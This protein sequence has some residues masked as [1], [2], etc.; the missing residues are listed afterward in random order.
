M[1]AFDTNVVVRLLLGDDPQQTA[2][3]IEHWQ[4]ALQTS[5]VFLPQVVILETIWVLSRAAKL[6]KSRI[7]SDL[8]QLVAI[9]GVSL[10]NEAVVK[11]AIERFAHSSA[12]FGDCVVLESARQ[13][14]ALPVITFD[15][16]FSRDGDVLLIP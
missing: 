1:Q 7:L 16:R 11:Q 6:D 10:E 15:Q 8:R 14:N 9:E 3:A 4:K 2:I 13:A 5:G 12:D